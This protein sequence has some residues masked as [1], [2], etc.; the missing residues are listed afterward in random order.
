MGWQLLHHACNGQGH[1]KA[2]SNGGVISHPQ[3]PLPSWTLPRGP[4]RWVGRSLP[5]LQDAPGTSD[6][7][8]SWC[9]V[10]AL[11]S[12]TRMHAQMVGSFPTPRVP[13]PLGP[14]LEGLL[15]GWADPSSGCRMALGPLIGMGAAAMCLQWPEA[16]ECMLKWWGHF[17]PPGSPTPLDPASRALSVGG[18]VTPRAA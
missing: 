18:Q 15:G 6:W 1:Q 17:P 16:P 8:G 13:S 4:S 11:V 9:T 3:G 10:F 5:G 14:C 2:F 7:G 12:G